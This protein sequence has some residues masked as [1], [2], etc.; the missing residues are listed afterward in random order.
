[1]LLTSPHFPFAKLRFFSI[2]GNRTGWSKNKTSPADLSGVKIEFLHFSVKSSQGD[3][4]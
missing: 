4:Q 3:T 2:L 1:M